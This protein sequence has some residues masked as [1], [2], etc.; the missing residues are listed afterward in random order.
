MV[1]RSNDRRDFSDHDR[2]VL[3]E[4]DLDDQDRK[5]ETIHDT[6]NRIL[7]TMIGILVSLVTGFVILYLQRH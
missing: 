6:M 7:W 1:P 2:I 3:G 5:Q 4:K